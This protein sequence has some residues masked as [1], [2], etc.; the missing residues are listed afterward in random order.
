MHLTYFAVVAGLLLQG[1]AAE[2]VVKF[3]TAASTFAPNWKAYNCYGKIIPASILKSYADEGEY[4]PKMFQGSYRHS[5]EVGLP[6]KSKDA[7]L[8]VEGVLTVYWTLP[9][10]VG[11]RFKA[12]KLLRRVEFQILTSETAVACTAA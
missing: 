3:S 7:E 9:I 10:I 1:T 5:Q 11:N 4:D 8:A 12:K 2:T 6:D